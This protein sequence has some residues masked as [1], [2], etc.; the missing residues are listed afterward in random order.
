MEQWP[1]R[2][3]GPPEPAAAPTADDV[4]DLCA[5]PHAS[6]DQALEIAARL[7]RAGWVVAGHPP[8]RSSTLLATIHH[9]VTGE[10]V[11]DLRYIGPPLH[12]PGS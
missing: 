12:E 3:T 5:D 9:P 8:E 11:G 4:A 6:L 7:R 1:P 10:V 2:P